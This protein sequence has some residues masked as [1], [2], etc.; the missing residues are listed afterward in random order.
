M[1]KLVVVVG[2]FNIDCFVNVRVG[3]CW[4]LVVFD[5]IDYGFGRIDN[6]GS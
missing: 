3:F 1:V 6:V 4:W 2:V 5:I